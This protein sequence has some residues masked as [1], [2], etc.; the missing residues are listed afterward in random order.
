MKVLH[1]WTRP[2]GKFILILQDGLQAK[3]VVLDNFQIMLNAPQPTC[4][5][6]GFGRYSNEPMKLVDISCAEVQI[7]KNVASLKQL[8]LLER[9][10]G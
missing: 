6:T 1:A 2:D 5:V 7:N 4:A 8:E 3:Q 9:V 10:R